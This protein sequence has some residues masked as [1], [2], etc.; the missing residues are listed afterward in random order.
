MTSPEQLPLVLR[1]GQ[2]TKLLSDCVRSVVYHLKT[3][4]DSLEK[5]M[6]HAHFVYSV[7]GFIPWGANET[8]KKAE[9]KLWYSVMLM[10]WL[11]GDGVKWSWLKV[12]KERED[13]RWL[14]IDQP[15][16]ARFIQ[17]RLAEECDRQGLIIDEYHMHVYESAAS[18]IG[19][20]Y[21]WDQVWGWMDIPL[22]FDEMAKRYST[23]GFRLCCCGPDVKPAEY[24]PEEDD[25]PTSRPKYL[26]DPSGFWDLAAASD[27]EAQPGPAVPVDS[28][29][30]HAVDDSFPP[31][32]TAKTAPA[33]APAA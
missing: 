22:T 27:R 31:A 14:R 23:V 10:K 11:K 28:D 8:I 13:Y 4:K 29:L 32:V 17:L 12:K 25:L 3:D 15:D 2:E 19:Y 9:H 30:V 1:F 7:C 20:P 21:V 6:N 16:Q 33:T 24:A 26:V 18:G 5:A